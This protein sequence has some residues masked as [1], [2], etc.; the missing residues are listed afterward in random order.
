M[1][2]PECPAVEQFKTSV[3]EDPMTAAMGAPVDDIFE[4]FDRRHIKGCKR[5]QQFNAENIGEHS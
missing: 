1:T 5:C 3:C 2:D 4:G